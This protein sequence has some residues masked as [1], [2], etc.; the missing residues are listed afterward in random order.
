M[1]LLPFTNKDN[2]LRL[3]RDDLITYY[4]RWYTPEN[5]VVVIVGD[6]QTEDAR[7]ASQVILGTYPRRSSP[8]IDL[9]EEPPQVSMRVGEVGMDIEIAYLRLAYRTI[10]VTDPDLYPLDLLSYILTRG[11]S[12]ILVRQIRDEKR[13]V[14]DI[15]SYS[16][17]PG[18]A[19]GMFA[20][21]AQLDPEKIDD[22]EDA[23]LEAIEN[24]KKSRFDSHVIEKAKKQKITEYIFANQSVEEQARNIARW[25]YLTTYD[26][27]F[28]AKYVDRI[29]KVTSEELHRV[30]N[31]YFSPENLTVARVVPH[32]YLQSSVPSGEK[33][34]SHEV[35]K[36]VLRNGMRLLT[37]VDDT[38]PLITVLAAF[39][40]GTLYEGEGES[41]ISNFA[42]RMLSKGTRGLSGDEI[43]EEMDLMGIDLTAS[44]GSNSFYVGFNLLAEDFERA[45]ELLAEMIQNPTF[46]AEEVE[47]MREQI[48]AGLARRRSDW[49]DE[50]SD[51]FRQVFFGDH[52]YRWPV[53]GSEEALKKMTAADLKEFHRR[54]VGAE[55]MVLSVFGDIEDLPVEET[56]DRLFSDLQREVDFDP[57]T[58]REWV[59]PAE[60]VTEIF[61]TDRKIAAIYMG[62]PGMTVDNVE[63]RYPMEVLDAV[64]SGIYYPGGWLHTQLRGRELVY[65]VHAFNWMG[66]DPGYF[67]IYAAT[68]PEQLEEAVSLIIEQMGRLK[69]EDIPDDE[70]EK[71]KGIAVTMEKLR[72]EPNYDQAL[73]SSLNELYGLGHD[74]HRKHEE[75]IQAV[76]EAEIKRV[77]EKYLNHYLLITALPDE[78]D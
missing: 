4:N 52:P 76:T 38:S 62:Y 45:M 69:S 61:P 21:T 27:H 35:E 41:G 10:S 7:Q 53:Q 30:L 34:I 60:N 47:R 39:R 70:L 44:G 59:G 77:A 68:T 58:R 40:G 43:A 31:Q 57:T 2:F 1:K 11:E 29:Q 20:I 13:L 37:K 51:H 66:L 19:G 64:T 72:Y 49:L 15:S 14:S 6:V 36:T 46:P 16:Y 25:A 48:L 32:E 18:Y 26:K 78:D 24:L 12:S 50:T 63:D 67:G 74:F 17:T 73:R 55:N 5:V 22:A 75:R 8:T 33:K 28:N 71:A 9:P 65:V 54:F 23:I 42:V 3:T 56:V